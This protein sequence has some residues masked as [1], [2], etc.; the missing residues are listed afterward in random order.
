MD[1]DA[2]VDDFPD[3]TAVQTVFVDESKGLSVTVS[4][5]PERIL[6]EKQDQAEK[7]RMEQQRNAIEDIK[8][9]DLTI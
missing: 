8:R 3:L 6:K 2:A 5:V 9:C 1:A 4:R 7:S